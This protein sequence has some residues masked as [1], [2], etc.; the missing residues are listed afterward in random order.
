MDIIGRRLGNSHRRLGE[1][2]K[3][4]NKWKPG[5]VSQT[6]D[7][8]AAGF[9]GF[10]VSLMAP[11][12]ATSEEAVATMQR[13]VNAFNTQIEYLIQEQIDSRQVSEEVADIMAREGISREDAEKAASKD[14]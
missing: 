13:M 5:L 11:P 2:M 10:G 6:K 14:D 4:E 7:G 9:S 8:W 3:V 12:E 1:E